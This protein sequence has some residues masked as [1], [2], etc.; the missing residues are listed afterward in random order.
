MNNREVVID[1]GQISQIW[2]LIG[3]EDHVGVA[4]GWQSWYIGSSGVDVH[5]VRLAALH[6]DNRKYEMLATSSFNHNIIRTKL[7]T[8]FDEKF[9]HKKHAHRVIFGEGGAFPERGGVPGRKHLG[10]G[11][12][13]AEGGGG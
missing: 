6:Y 7:T 3:A 10:E 1:W 2:N 9:C 11:S 8:T 13:L 4:I 5:D 12:Y